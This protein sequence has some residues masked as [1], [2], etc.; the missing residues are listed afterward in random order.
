LAIKNKHGPLLATEKQARSQVLRFGGKNEL[1]GWQD[2]CFYCIFKT[3][4]SRLNKIW[5]EQKKIGRNCPR[6]A[7]VATGLL[8][9]RF[10]PP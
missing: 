4:F 5:E 9:R 3:N 7:P 2:F 10:E 1:L 6:M 8:Q